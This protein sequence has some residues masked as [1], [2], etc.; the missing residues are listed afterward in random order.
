MRRAQTWIDMTFGSSLERVRR[1]FDRES[2]RHGLR[3]EMGVASFRLV[4]NALLPIQQRLLEEAAAE[5]LTPLMERGSV[6]TIAYERR[7]PLFANLDIV[8]VFDH[9]AQ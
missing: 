9:T 5:R 2:T 6:I 1:I 8:A 3:G 4:H 7:I